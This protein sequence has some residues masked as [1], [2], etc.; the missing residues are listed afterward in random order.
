MRVEV[1]C[2]S[3]TCRN[4]IES[5][6]ALPL[7]FVH[8]EVPFSLFGSSFGRCVKPLQWHLDPSP[9]ARVWIITV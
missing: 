1:Q 6:P 9:G 8:A 4:G 5:D 7:A 3:S 2:R